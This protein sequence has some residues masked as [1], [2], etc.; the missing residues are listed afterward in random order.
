MM[1]MLSIDTGSSL[2]WVPAVGMIFAIWACFVLPLRWLDARKRAEVALSSMAAQDVEVFDGVPNVGALGEMGLF[3]LTVAGFLLDGETPQR[4][5][6]IPES[7]E[8]I[9]LNGALLDPPLWTDVAE[10]AIPAEPSSAFPPR[11]AEGFGDETNLPMRALTGEEL[12][13]LRKLSP[14]REM[15]R[16]HGCL[17]AFIVYI[18]LG[19]AF[20]SPSKDEVGLWPLFWAIRIL[21]FGFLVWT[22]FRV[23]RERVLHARDLSEASV[24][25]VMDDSTRLE[26][27]PNL[28]A[29]WTVEGEPSPWRYAAQAKA[30]PPK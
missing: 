5:E 15:L 24:I 10:V 23:N 4:V 27:L 13:E 3:E 6:R 22:F 26:V 29:V 17:L 1:L 20:Q 19:F 30:R 2:A 7:G 12:E 14:P 25:R 16:R 11:I 28:K 8:V 9:H 18:F 21:T